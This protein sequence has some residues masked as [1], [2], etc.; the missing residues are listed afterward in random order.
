MGTAVPFPL[1]RQYRCKLNA[2]RVES[3]ISNL[4]LLD[5]GQVNGRFSGSAFPIMIRAQRVTDIISNQ[6]FTGSATVLQIYPC[7]S[8]FHIAEIAVDVTGKSVNRTFQRTLYVMTCPEHCPYVAAVKRINID[9]MLDAVSFRITY[10]SAYQLVVVR[11]AAASSARGRAICPAERCWKP[12]GPR[13]QAGPPR[14]A[15]CPPSPS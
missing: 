7:P 6:R 10:K 15:V 8:G 4:E 9:T 13:W 11:S 5:I 3:N 12:R 1:S 2:H 14:T